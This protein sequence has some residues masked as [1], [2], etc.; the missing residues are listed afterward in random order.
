MYMQMPACP[1]IGSQQAALKHRTTCL[2]S[3]SYYSCAINTIP[4][5]SFQRRLHRELVG[6]VT[7]PPEGVE[8]DEK[9]REGKDISRYFYSVG[10][11][12]FYQDN[13]HTVYFRW[14]VKVTGPPDTLYEGETYQLSF[15]FGS[16]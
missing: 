5:L 11:L 13:G 9:T 16:R 12:Y 14:R 4:F 8:V 1:F 10:Y 2:K 15:V 3:V 6:L 7:D